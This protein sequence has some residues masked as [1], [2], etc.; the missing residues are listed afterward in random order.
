MKLKIFLLSALF[1]SGNLAM[2]QGT[3]NRLLEQICE[4]LGRYTALQLAL[5][6]AFSSNSTVSPEQNDQ[7]RKNKQERKKLFIDIVANA[8]RLGAKIQTLAEIG[9]KEVIYSEQRL[10]ELKEY[11]AE[12]KR[13]NAS[14]DAAFD[15]LVKHVNALELTIF[16]SKI[17]SHNK[18][19]E[20][21]AYIQFPDEINFGP[22]I[23]ECTI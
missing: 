10:E 4:D 13:I 11:I 6:K 8:G 15:D 9:M 12:E 1:F 3:R 20:L 14:S 19:D 23:V 22:L 5:T 16:C 2:D 21:T 18:K 17:R 7:E